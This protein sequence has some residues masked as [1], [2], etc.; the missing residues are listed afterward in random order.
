MDHAASVVAYNGIGV[1]YYATMYL[2]QRGLASCHMIERLRISDEGS[3]PEMCTWFI[4]LI[5]SDFKTVYQE[6]VWRSGKAL[7][8]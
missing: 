8:L 3:I 4:L 6:Q 5:Q 1:S 7:G 2:N